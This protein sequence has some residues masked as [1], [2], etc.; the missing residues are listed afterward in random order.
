MSG[1][2]NAIT[3]AY[4]SRHGVMFLMAPWCNQAITEWANSSGNASAVLPAGDR[5][6]TVWHA[7]DGK[8]LGLWYAGTEANIRR[9]AKPGAIVFF[10]WAGSDG[11]PYVDHVG[12]V[13]VN[14]GDGRVQTIEG[15]TGDTCKRRVRASNV[16]AGF[17]NPPYTEKRDT[18]VM[19]E[20]LPLLKPGAKG[21]HAKTAFFLLKARGYAKTLDEKTIDPTVYSPKV[22]AEV[23][24]LQKAEDLKPDG[25]VGPKT[26]PAL[27]GL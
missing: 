9:Y 3:R 13:E 17:W 7:E 26:W 22:V 4:A 19:V 6:Y 21:K 27:L 15:N 23:K 2:P 1:R 20:K 5:A 11:I 18:E 24:R 12:I 25:E 14:L 10:D 8:R 16:I